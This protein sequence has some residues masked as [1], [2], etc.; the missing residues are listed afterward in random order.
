MSEKKEQ[1]TRRSVLIA[2]ALG[3]AAVASEKTPVFA[4]QSQSTSTHKD[5]NDK[6]WKKVAEVFGVEGKIEPGDV[7]LIDLPRTDLEPVAFGISLKPEIGFDSEIT[8]QHTGKGAIV[9]YELTL[10]DS[11]VE[12]VLSAL[13]AQNLQ[14]LTTT[15]NALHNHFIELTPKIKYLHGTST[16]DP[17]QIARAIREALSHS[18]QPFVSSSPGDTELPNKEIE[19]IIGG[20][21][22]ISDSVLSV[23]V[24]RKEKIRELGVV[25]EPAMQ[26]ESLFNFQSIDDEQAAVNAEFILLPSEVDAVARKLR[27]HGF[28][29]MAVHN[30]ELFIEP[31]FYYLHSFGTGESLALAHTIREALNKTNSRFK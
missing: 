16:G 2:S 19:R 30:H 9:K 7:L 14:P 23:S 12:P 1:I 15:L 17:V 22:M 18:E 27:S 20:M 13:F 25:L 21:G 3:V 8:F 24:E 31:T 26:V 28:K 10:L 4:Q 6:E 5:A 29:I 11:E